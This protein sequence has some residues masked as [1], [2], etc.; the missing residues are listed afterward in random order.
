MTLGI[1][2]KNLDT[3]VHNSNSHISVSESRF[4][5]RNYFFVF[6]A[7]SALYVFTCAPGAVWQDAGV[8]QYR[9]WHNDIQGKYGLAL[10]HPLF[11]LIAILFKHIPLGEFTY[12]INCLSALISALAVANLYLLLLRT[13]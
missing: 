5:W 2:I 11:Y 6:L 8:I 13:L 3:A 10:S 4:P 7:A 1:R 12:R 9:V